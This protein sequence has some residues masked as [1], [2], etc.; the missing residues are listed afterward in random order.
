L[1]K[2]GYLILNRKWKAGDIVDLVLPMPVRKITANEKVE[3]DKGKL[4]IQRGPLVYCTEWADAADGHVLDLVFDPQSPM[5]TFYDPKLLN[6]VQVITATASKVRRTPEGNIVLGE[7]GELVM[8]PYYAWANRGAGEMV[9]W[10]PT[11]IDLVTHYL[12]NNY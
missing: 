8:I 5:Q 3:E 2:G 7:P 9:V 11:E 10:I 6:G 4:A 12:N 1:I